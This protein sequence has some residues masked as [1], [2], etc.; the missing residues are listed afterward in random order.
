MS[1]TTLAETAVRDARFAVRILRKSPAFAVT[2]SMTLALA[3]AVNTAIF[4]VVDAVLLKPLPYPEPDRLAMVTTTVRAGGAVQ[5]DTAQNGATWLM[6]RDHATTIDRAAY[7]TWP[8]GV[9]I[10]AAGRASHVQQQRVGAGFFGVLGVA[11]IA[12]RAF[13]ADEDR[14]GGPAAAILSHA[15][16][17][18]MFNADPSVVG[19]TLGVRGEATTIV[20]VMPAGFHSGTGADL[21]TPLRPN[22]TGE[23][24]GENYA[25]LARL[26][27]GI[28]WAQ[29]DA[30]M[31][32]IG[33]EI[34][35]QRQPRQGSSIAFSLQPLQ[36]GMTASLRT[37]LLMLWSAVGIV[38]L[39][40]CVNLAGLLLARTSARSREIATRMALGGGRGAVV[41]QLVVESFVLAALGW[42]AGIALGAIALEALKAVAA[43]AFDIW[44]PVS[45]DARAVTVAAALSFGAS[46][47]FGIA[48]AFQ[49]TRLD[50]Q[51][52]LADAGSRAVATRG[53]LWPRRLLIVIQVALGV[54]LLVGAGLLV[55]TFSHLRHLDPGFDARGVVTAS[56]SL[57]DARYR[58]AARVSQLFGGTLTRVSQAPGVEVAAVS[59]GLP[60]ERLLNLGFRHLDGPQAGSTQGQMTSATYIA[61]DFFRALRIPLRAG[62]TFDARDRSDGPGVVVVNDTFVRQ[63][64]DGA[65]PLGRRIAFAGR[66]REIVGVV[67]DVQ[68][69]P[70]WGQNGPIAAMPLAYI[71]LAQATDGFLRLVHGWFSP[72]YVV[73]ATA[74]TDS[75]GALRRAVDETDP[76]LPF[77][78]VRSMEEVQD[79]SLAQ[80]RFLMVLLAGLALAAVLLAAVG[81]HGLVATTVV[82]RT[83]EM[84]IRVAL[85]ATRGHAMRT[86]AIPGV[87]LA[88]GGTVLGAIASLGFARLLGHYVWGVS[89]TDPMTFLAVGAILLVVASIASF[90]PALRILRMEP[91]TTLR[92]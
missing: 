2:A 91:A 44:Q 4:S 40:S 6:I 18:A 72:A 49:A 30:E 82:E 46:V 32:Q 8:I 88:L 53:K 39:I 58:T 87:V 85:G 24:E 59:L 57:Q 51:A 38:L 62:R 54:I 37:P 45:L 27:P 5:D 35:R 74:A 89:P 69:R 47:V 92:H 56:V 61:G 76:L 43:D 84:G 83:R 55:R 22:A 19:T 14:P 50:V 73:R 52:A 26:R 1:P 15:L 29:A 80:Q 21:W 10:V 9:N 67:G 70:G 78:R 79:A 31:R 60:Y 7:S 64:F 33:A 42:T 68:V 77:A 66:E 90:G 17:R 48:P 16:W 13:T 28:A 36:R 34:A 11:P 65:S 25:I 41:R 23:G 63:Y 81:I 20:G 71:P 12:G 3:I 86:L 75:V